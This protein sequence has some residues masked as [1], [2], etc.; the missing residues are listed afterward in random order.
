MGKTRKKY[1]VSVLV[2]LLFLANYSFAVSVVSC[3]MSMGND[4]NCY[5][6][7]ESEIHS[8]KNNDFSFMFYSEPGI[9]CYE[10]IQELNNECDFNISNKDKAEIVLA[11]SFSLNPI[12][13]HIF[14]CNVLKSHFSIELLN[15]NS[16]NLP[17][18]YSSLLI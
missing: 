5:C 10:I 3:S 9:C 14:S 6:T 4:C 18:L 15:Y 8:E 2:L 16:G 12:S 1:F 11:L 7:Q 13:P 17:I